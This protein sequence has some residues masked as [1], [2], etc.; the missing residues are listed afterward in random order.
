MRKSIISGLGA[1]VI[2]ALIAVGISFFWSNLFILFLL[3]GCIV[4]FAVRLTGKR[5]DIRL[6]VIGGVFS[7][8]ACILALFLIC[9]FNNTSF[10]G[11]FVDGAWIPMLL[12]VV[13]GAVQALNNEFID[14]P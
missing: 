10:V 8:V 11:T 13:I 3:A 14:N 1:S 5:K 12:T 2:G 9:V 6:A 4:G 7:A